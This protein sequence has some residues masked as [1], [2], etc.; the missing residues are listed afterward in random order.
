MKKVMIIGGGASGMMAAI[1]ASLSGAEVLII[2]QNEKT[3]KKI[4]STGNGRCNFTNTK[5][6]PSCYRSDDPDFPWQVIQQFDE[7]RTIAFFKEI[8]IL[9]K[10]RNGY[11]YPNSDQAQA[12]ADALQM[13]CERL[14]I[15]VIRNTA[16]L[17][18]TPRKRGFLLKTETVEREEK[19]DKKK[20]SKKDFEKRT[21][22]TWTCDA[23]IL[24]CGSKAS[25]IS[26]SDG[27]GYA[28]AKS[29]GHSLV[30]VLPALVQLHCKEAFYKEIAGI[31]IQGKVTIYANEQPLFEDCGEIQ[32]T[33]Y[34]ISGIPVFQVSRYAA[35][36]LYE[37]KQ[38]K[39]VL[40]FMPEYTKEECVRLLKE[41]ILSR[42]EKKA[43][44]FFIGLFPKKLG[45]LFLE[46]SRLERNRG[47]QTLS[48]QEIDSLTNLIR[49]F[50]TTVVKTN[51]FEQAQICCGGVDT[52]EVDPQTMES[53]YVPGLYFTGELLDV[54]GIC[55]GYNL[56]WAW[57]SGYIGGEN[58]ARKSDQ[59]RE[60]YV[61][62]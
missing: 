50:E 6:D 48:D 10:N 54:D 52:R 32:L 42:P 7:N 38:V 62:S 46:L 44:D 19:K 11:L 18:I 29:V 39:A 22:N 23:V 49:H 43:E 2:E 13:E 31:R 61:I 20:K 51:S 45:D 30:P 27:S 12:V 33:N 17:E 3:G 40:N 16:C 15:C 58:A 4:L 1:S 28:L 9:P 47:V 5:Q 53:R 35:K 26:G 34:G 14:G 41:R 24:A 36:A 37:K 59:N 57:S 55:G 8:G 25:N 56:Q 21:T 60:S